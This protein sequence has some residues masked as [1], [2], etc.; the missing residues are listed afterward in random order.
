MQ[1]TLLKHEQAGT[2]DDPEYRKATDEYY[3][4]HLFRGADMPDYL[5]R[6]L[7]QMAKYPEVYNVMNGPSEFFV[8]GV[9]KDW[10]ITPRLGEIRVPTLVLGGRFDEATPAITY[11][12]HRGIPHSQFVIFENSAHM[13]H[14]EEAEHFRQVLT[15]FLRRVER[16]Q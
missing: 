4:R 1:R 3:R 10:D 12:V 16:H 6:T 5:Q 15:G 11:A 2:I 7:D 8:T 9:L 13:P 14:I